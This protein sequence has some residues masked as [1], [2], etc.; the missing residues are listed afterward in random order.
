MKCTRG[1]TFCH[2]ASVTLDRGKQLGFTLL[3]LLS[4][5]LIVSVLSLLLFDRFL[6]YQALA[7][8]TAMEMTVINMRSGLRL[9]VAELMMQDRMNE[10][11]QLVHENP[12]S[13]LAAPPPNY[14]GQF[15]NPEQSAIATNTWYFDS[16]RH[17]LVYV[18]GRDNIFGADAA[19]ARTL[20]FQVTSVER[21]PVNGVSS[22]PK[23]EG[24]ALVRVARQDE[25]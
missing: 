9:R 14:S 3:E 22:A 10:V 2:R 20:R 15:Q 8:K 5:I 13:W 7:E 19:H 25:Y 24:V 6:G 21:P 4:I 23:I 16:R 12:I 11:G 17:E 1:G 18:L